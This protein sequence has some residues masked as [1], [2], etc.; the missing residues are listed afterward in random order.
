V[1]QSGKFVFLEGT[2]ILVSIIVAV[3]GPKTLVPRE[4]KS[5]FNSREGPET[6]DGRNVIGPVNGSRTIGI[7]KSRTS[8]QLASVP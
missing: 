7:S 5:R 1:F 6:P 3:G 8:Q 4:R 2:Q